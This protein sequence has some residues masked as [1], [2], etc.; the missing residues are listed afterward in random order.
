MED[1]STSTKLARELIGS[2]MLLIS[3]MPRHKKAQKLKK[4]RADIQSRIVYSKE[5]DSDQD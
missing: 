2:N 5:S 3:P 1:Q 4:I